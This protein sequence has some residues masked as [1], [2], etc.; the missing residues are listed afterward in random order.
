MTLS[1][2]TIEVAVNQIGV[3]EIPRGSNAGPEVEIYLKSVGLKKGYAWCMAL[4][5]WV[6]QEASKL[7]NTANPLKKT[8]G[9]LDQWN[10]R[11]ELRIKTP[12]PGCVF[13]IDFGKGLGHAGIVEHVLPDGRIATIEGNTNTDGSREGYAVCR[14]IR[15]VYQITGFLKI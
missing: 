11:P 7:T 10:S 2:K 14:R 6:V 8:A 5:Y 15:T 4:C 9:V 3:Q 12:V 13:I 1:Q